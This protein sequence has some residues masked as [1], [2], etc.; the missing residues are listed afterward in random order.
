[1]L[2]ILVVDD[3]DDT[4]ITYRVALQREGFE[5][6]LADSCFSAIQTLSTGVAFHAQ[7]LDLNLP[8]GNGYDVLRWM[9]SERHFV[10]TAVITKFRLDFDPD[11]AIELGALAYVDQPLWIDTLVPLARSL[12]RPITEQDDPDELH[13]RVVAGDPC[14]LECLDRIF[15]KRLP[16]RLERAF[17]ATAWDLLTEAVSDACLE[18]GAAAA[19]LHPCGNRSIIDLMFG[20]AW[21]NVVDRN[22][23]ENSRKN[24]EHRWALTKSPLVMPDVEILDRTIDVAATIIA[25][26]KDDREYQAARIWLSGGTR[27]EIGAALVGRLSDSASRIRSG[28]QFIDRL[29]KRLSRCITPKNIYG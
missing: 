10:P 28:K 11:E 5:V 15:L 21:R 29:K 16:P 19:R 22:R 7:L 18:Y 6:A 25:V 13:R 4:G 1:M 17:P 2:R 26:T 24:R 12:S 14:A 20:I 9:Q 27:E 8:D 3:D 23:S